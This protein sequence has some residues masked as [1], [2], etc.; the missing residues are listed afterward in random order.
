MLKSRPQV[1]LVDI[2]LPGIDGYEVARRVRAS[3]D[4][5]GVYL[6]ALTGYGGFDGHLTK[7][8]D[9]DVLTGLLERRAQRPSRSAL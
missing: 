8:V 3:R 6:I 1:A 9:V 4:G 2:G 5:R 7:P